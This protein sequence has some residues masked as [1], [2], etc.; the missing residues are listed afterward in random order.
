MSLRENVIAGA[1]VVAAVAAVLGVM[2]GLYV[3]AMNV[4]ATKDD[5]ATMTA[6]LATKADVAALPTRTEFAAVNETV[7]DLRVTLAAL[8]GTV[9]ELRSTVGQVTSAVNTLSGTVGQVTSA[10]NTLS[11]TVGQVTSAVNTLSGT[12][13]Q[14]IAAGGRIDGAVE[15]MD[16]GLDYLNNI[17][18]PLV[19]CVIELHGFRSPEPEPERTAVEQPSPQPGAVL[20]QGLMILRP[21]L[22]ETCVQARDRARLGVR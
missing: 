5:I 2:G 7:N 18:S 14:V 17:V 13:D 9:Q 8:D 1:A 10:V 3:F 19:P 21:P 15:S 12:V 6:P 16:G 4:P 11:G 22:P 20:T